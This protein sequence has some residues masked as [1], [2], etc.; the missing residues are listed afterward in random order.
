MRV[1]LALL[2][3]AGVALGPVVALA[4]TG[5]G[6]RRAP[7]VDSLVRDLR[8]GGLTGTDLVDEAIAAVADAFPKYSLWRLWLSP[9]QALARQA[10]WSHQ[11][12]TVLLLVLRR[13]GFDVRLVHAARVRGFG[14]PWWLAGHTWAKVS[15]DGVEFD[16]C[17]SRRDNRAGD[18]GFVPL[19]PEL[20]M[21]RITRWAVGSALVPFIVLGVWRAILTGSDVPEWIEGNKEGARQ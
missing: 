15:V 2:A 10:G 12:N 21:R 20:P 6:Q 4:P 5:N 16:A 8:A 13:L 1:K 19:T 17:A 9:E 11:Y 7:T 18:C 3:A 14:R